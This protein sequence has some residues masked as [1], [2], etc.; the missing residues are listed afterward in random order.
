MSSSAAHGGFECDGCGAC[1]ETW[2]VL[3]SEEDAVREPRIRAESRELPEPQRTVLWRFVLFPLPFHGSCCFLDAEKR[4]T[5][6]ETRPRVC[7]EFEA[8]SPRCQEA[9]GLA[10]LAPLA[11]ATIGPG[12]G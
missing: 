3:V 10:G 11:P 5:V 2:R 1:C 12:A 9:R 7:R 8:G 4:C 6:Y